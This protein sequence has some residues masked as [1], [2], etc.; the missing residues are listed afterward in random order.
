MP[1]SELGRC[2][3][4]LEFTLNSAIWPRRTQTSKQLVALS[5]SWP[6]CLTFPKK[7]QKRRSWTT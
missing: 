5:I 2:V 7:L 1:I 3:N 6:S 4:G